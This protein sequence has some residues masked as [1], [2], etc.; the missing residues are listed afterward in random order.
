MH[1]TNGVF[2]SRPVYDLSNAW[3]TRSATL[4]SYF[5]PDPSID[6]SGLCLPVS[7]DLPHPRREQV[8]I[9]G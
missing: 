9:A 2:L 5:C 4:I 1:Y 7:G 8:V 3:K 6:I